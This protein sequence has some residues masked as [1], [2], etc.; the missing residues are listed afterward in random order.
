MKNEEFV[1]AIGVSLVI[2]LLVGMIEYLLSIIDGK[3]MLQY[4]L[5]H[6]VCFPDIGS[7][8]FLPNNAFC[9]DN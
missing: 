1:K 7:I 4:I 6:F 8:S 3:I 5:E 9:Y 2:S